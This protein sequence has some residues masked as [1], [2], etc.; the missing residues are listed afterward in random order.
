M[1]HVRDLG[2]GPPVVFL[3]PGPGLDGSVFL[4]G[5]ER[6]ARSHRVLLADL[7]G[8]GRSEDGDRNEWTLAGFARAVE[9]LA[10]QLDL[11]DWT[12]LGHSF[13]GFVALQHLVDFPDS[14]A[15]LVASCTDASETPAPGE[16]ED[17]LAGLSPEQRE[18]CEEGE[19]R[20]QVAASPRELEDAWLAQAGRLVADEADLGPMLRDVVFRPVMGRPREWGELE[21]LGAL[22]L[23][24]KPVLAIGAEH[25]RAIAQEAARRIAATAP[26]GDLL[27]IEGSGHFPFAE[28]PERYWP[29]LEDWLFRTA[30]GTL[31]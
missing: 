30:P 24:R 21:A 9:Q 14:A 26:H 31:A 25:D 19:A 7:P 28:A 20:E 5:A 29:P 6:L 27:M 22:A 13:G 4:P 18:R 10:A 2:S 8:N 12:L 1:M 3:H 23:T 16:P 17:P 11:R 15:R